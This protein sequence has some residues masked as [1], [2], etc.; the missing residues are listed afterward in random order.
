LIHGDVFRFPPHKNIFSA[1]LGIGSQFMAIVVF[2]L[3]FSLFGM[4]YPTNGGNM[5]ASAIALYA[6]TAG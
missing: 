1:F 3:L 4:Y 5:Y 6:V 2:T